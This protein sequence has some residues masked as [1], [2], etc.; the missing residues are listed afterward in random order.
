[1]KVAGVGE[2]GHSVRQKDG[3][4]L[5]LFYEIGHILEVYKE[6]HMNVK[7]FIFFVK[8]TRLQPRHSKK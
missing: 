6:G 5:R 8:L 1:M 3:F 2:K 7:L 4:V